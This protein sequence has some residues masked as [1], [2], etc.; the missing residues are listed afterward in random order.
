M[1][2]EHKIPNR[3]RQARIELGLTQKQLAQAM[4]HKSA[5]RISLWERGEK[6]PSLVN[7]IA[8]SI[9][10]KRLV[11]DLFSNIRAEL[12]PEIAKRLETIDNN[13]P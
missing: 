13:S 12:L 1:E 10:C 2:Q 9:I 6:T 4:G 11:D 7:A 8:L 3:L 5:H